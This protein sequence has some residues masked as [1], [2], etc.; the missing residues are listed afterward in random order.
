M[1]DL[2]HATLSIDVGKRR[3]KRREMKETNEKCVWREEKKKT[4][5]EGRIDNVKVIGFPR[6]MYTR[7]EWRR[8]SLKR[9]K[10]RVNS[11]YSSR[12]HFTILSF[13]HSSSSLYCLGFVSLVFGVVFFF[14]LSFSGK[15]ENMWAA[16]SFSSAHTSR[17]S[18]SLVRFL[19]AAA[20]DRRYSELSSLFYT[21]KKKEEENNFPSSSRNVFLFS[22]LLSLH[23]SS[24][25]PRHK[26]ACMQTNNVHA[27]LSSSVCLS[28]NEFT[29]EFIFIDIFL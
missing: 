22:L 20:A 12:A 6:C 8:K 2:F 18:S 27:E 9:E 14:F 7:R 16:I 13:L 11:I 25:S 23:L 24:S 5:E 21:R 4:E 1:S 10:E 26:H 19:T 15:E 29:F 17:C 28:L 3:W